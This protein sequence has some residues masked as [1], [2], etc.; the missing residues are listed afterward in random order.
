MKKQNIPLLTATLLTVL[1]FFA[2]TFAGDM[3]LQLIQ[4]ARES[5]S[6]AEKQQIW[7]MARCGWHWI[8]FDLLFASVGLVLV[9]FTRFFEHPKMVLKILAFYF[10][11]YALV[12]IL[13]LIIS[14]SFSF[15]FLKLGQWILLLA[16]SALIYYGN[17]KIKV[18]G[19]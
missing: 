4:P 7:T 15:N 8:S 14:P 17:K 16:I 1:A 10:A 18:S 5:D 13:V 6:W 11:G 9:S 12:W 2:H 3:E 19:S